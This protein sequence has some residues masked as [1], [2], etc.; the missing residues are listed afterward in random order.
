MTGLPL[1]DAFGPS[2]NRTADSP[3]IRRAAHSQPAFGDIFDVALERSTGRPTAGD[4]NS[5]DRFTAHEP[6]RDTTPR[7][8]SSELGD[9]ARRSRAHGDDGR[10]PEAD[11]GDENTTPASDRASA[12]AVEVTSAAGAVAVAIHSPAT[13]GAEQPAPGTPTTAHQASAP[14][15]VAMA[16][17]VARDPAVDATAAATSAAPAPSVPAPSVPASSVPASSV[18][19]SPGTPA[20]PMGANDTAPATASST[21][22]STVSCTVSA[23]SDPVI[24]ADPAS[25]TATTTGPLAATTVDPTGADGNAGDTA[26]R[27]GTPTPPAPDAASTVSA[28][29]AVMDAPDPQPTTTRPDAT[30][31]AASRAPASSPLGETRAAT[32]YASR[33][34]QAPPPTLPSTWAAPDDGG[35]DLLARAELNRLTAGGSRM[36]V[37]LSTSELGSVRVEATHRNGQLH[38]D[39]M[40]NLASTRSLLADHVGELRDDLR[41]GG[42]DL[43]SVDVK[44]GGSSARDALPRDRR[45][46]MATPTGPPAPDV[47]SPDTLTRVADPARAADLADDR[48]DVRL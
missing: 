9:A 48:V 40:S 8:E 24:A 30:G 1:I 21:A 28:D 42:L 17:T 36:G 44:S 32:V 18:P 34:G 7:R 31:A 45:T 43:D 16:P 27:E 14:S 12:K 33:P 13:V 37:D 20:S 23:G 4:R 11:P 3:S 5:H 38:L 2:T 47:E 22:S 6:R 26:Q 29:D 25:A 15:A 19:A 46:V 41:A 10:V 35:A 39:L